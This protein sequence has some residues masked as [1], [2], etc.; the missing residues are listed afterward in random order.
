MKRNWYNILAVRFYAINQRF[1]IVPAFEFFDHLRKI[2][3]RAI[4]N[5]VF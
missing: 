1:I 2:D 4:L 3:K 5:I